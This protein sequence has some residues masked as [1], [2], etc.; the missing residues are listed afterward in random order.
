MPTPPACQFYVLS[1]HRLFGAQIVISQGDSNWPGWEG[2][3]AQLAWPERL[4]H[5]QWAK[6]CL[7]I[8]LRL[9]PWNVPEKG[10]GWMCSSKDLC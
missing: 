5:V 7:P 3:L 9:G 8:R 6:L 1:P 4:D 2:P 10:T